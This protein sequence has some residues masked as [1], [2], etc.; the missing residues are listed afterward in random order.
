MCEILLSRGPSPCPVTK[1]I[2]MV[3]EIAIYRQS[4]RLPSNWRLGLIPVSRQ[5]RPPWVIHIKATRL[6]TLSG[7]GLELRRTIFAKVD[8]SLA[9]S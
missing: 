9:R 7:N 2:G 6:I 5:T 3:S 8:R 4:T 1:P